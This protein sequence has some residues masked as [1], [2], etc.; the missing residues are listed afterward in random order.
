MLGWSGAG[1]G[2]IT[3][4]GGDCKN[5]TETKYHDL[6]D[7]SRSTTTTNNNNN[8]MTHTHTPTGIALHTGH[9]DKVFLT[10]THAPSA[11]SAEISG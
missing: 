5:K 7:M 8:N 9:A 1:K 3:G 6:R 2:A 10:I 4:D 11:P